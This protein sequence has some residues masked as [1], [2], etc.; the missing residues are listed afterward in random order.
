MFI[1][2][3]WYFYLTI[4]TALELKTVFRL[5]QRQP[6]GLIGSVIGLSGL[7]L[8]GPDHT[9]FCRRVETLEVPQPRL[10]P[11]NVR[12]GRKPTAVRSELGPRRLP[13]ASSR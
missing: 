4:L 11:R 9:T 5:A 3:T 6:G 10:R 8:A 13:A 1:Q 12:P 2:N 7:S